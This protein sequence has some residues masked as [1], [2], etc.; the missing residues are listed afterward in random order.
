MP[1]VKIGWIDQK[2]NSA[3]YEFAL[4]V[5]SKNTKSSNRPERYDPGDIIILFD[6]MPEN[7]SDI[8]RD[9]RPYRIA[10][11]TDGGDEDDDL[12]PTKYVMT[13]SGKIDAADETS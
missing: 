1:F 5:D 7:T 4:E 13:A 12:P 6:V 9:G 2:Q 10:F 8:T 11:I 3:S